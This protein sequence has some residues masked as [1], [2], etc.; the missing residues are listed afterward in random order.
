MFVRMNPRAILTGVVLVLMGY[1]FFSGF[2]PNASYSYWLAEF[3]AD[4]AIFILVGI[5]ILI[6]GVFSRN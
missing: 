2:F 4:G 5:V 3:V 6:V 1:G